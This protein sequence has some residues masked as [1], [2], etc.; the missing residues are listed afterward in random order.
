MSTVSKVGHLPYF[1]QLL[2]SYIRSSSMW[3]VGHES[4]I[5]IVSAVRTTSAGFLTSH[6]RMNVML[7]RCKQG[8]VV[9][10]Q[11][12]FLRNGGRDTLLGKL[13]EHWEKK[14]G[15]KNTWADAMEVADGRAKLP[16]VQ[17]PRT[18]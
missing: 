17:T 9:V 15:E 11:R 1:G 18:A 16:Q 5:I 14:I 12:A 4:P 8:M 2:S 3:F 10:T 13:A 6:N 7:T